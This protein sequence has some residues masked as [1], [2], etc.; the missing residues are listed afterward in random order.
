MVV[1]LIDKITKGGKTDWQNN[2]RQ[3]VVKLID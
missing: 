2:E 3:M 1:K